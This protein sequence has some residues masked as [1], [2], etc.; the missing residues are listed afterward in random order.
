MKQNVKY[1][2]E[3]KIK[4]SGQTPDLKNF[5]VSDYAKE[6]MG[7]PEF[8]IGAAEDVNI[9][10][11]S[12]D[13]L[14]VTGWSETKFFGQEGWE[15]LKTLGLAPCLPDDAP[16]IRMVHDMQKQNEWIRIAHDPILRA[17]FITRQ[18]R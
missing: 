16:Y 8:T 7:K 12:V 13:A 17:G 11:Y 1:E 10:V 9:R 2:Y 14:G 5:F 3:F 6:M 4:K 18:P 15:Y